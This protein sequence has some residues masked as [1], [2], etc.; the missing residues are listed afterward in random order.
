MFCHKR[1]VLFFRDERDN[2]LF[3][4]LLIDVK[5]NSLSTHP[6]RPSFSPSSPLHLLPSFIEIDS[7]STVVGHVLT[8]ENAIF[9]IVMLIEVFFVRFNEVK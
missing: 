9:H 2:S 5:L 6:S 4:L 7:R 3:T 8:E 1:V